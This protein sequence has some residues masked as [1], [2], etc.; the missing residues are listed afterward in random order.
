MDAIRNGLDECFEERSGGSHV[1]LFDELDH[2]EL[3]GAV[4][5]HEQVELAFGGSHLSQVDV[6]EADRIRIKLLPARSVTLDLG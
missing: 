1:C 3:R 5:G 4:D 6:E 2:S